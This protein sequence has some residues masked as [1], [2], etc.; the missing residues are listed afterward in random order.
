MPAQPSTVECLAP[1]PSRVRPRVSL[2]RRAPTYLRASHAAFLATASERLARSLD[3]QQ[4]LDC[5]VQL[6]VPTL[7]DVCIVRTLQDGNPTCDAM[8]AFHAD[9]RRQKLLEKV[10]HSAL[11]DSVGRQSLLSVAANRRP[12][13]LSP[14]DT[15]LLLGE[16]TTPDVVPGELG[17]STA[18]LVPVV[19]SVRTTAV[20]ALLSASDRLYPRWKIG[21]AEELAARFALALEAARMYRASRLAFE[22]REEALATGIH[23][24]MSPLSFIKGTVQR[25]RRIAPSISDAV[26]ESDFTRRLDAMD[27]AAERMASALSALLRTTIPHPHDSLHPPTQR[28]DLVDLARR[29]IEVEQLHT[30][31][32]VI[33]LHARPSVLEGA[34]DADALER[35][36]TNL[37]GNAVKYSPTGGDVDVAVA[38]EA[39]DEEHLAV[40]RVTDLGVGI[41]P[42]DLPFVFEPFRRGSNVVQIGGT[43][44]GLTS[45]FQIVKAHRGHVSVDSSEGKGTCVTVRLPVRFPG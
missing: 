5:L 26:A 28:T 44:L 14:S 18:L 4:T 7:G 34:W 11:G 30:T 15:A 42:G 35:L 19:S 43:G 39:D 21:L 31:E 3:L 25:L 8:A 1:R 2:V 9:S 38:L 36:L 20:M 23:D 32:H 24:L 13:A 17:V 41:P 12:A 22:D 27:S 10:A 40:L 16:G 37:I 29:V 45:V 6:A 33:T